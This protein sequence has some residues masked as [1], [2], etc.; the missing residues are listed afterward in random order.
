MTPLVIRMRD[1]SFISQGETVVPPQS[2]DVAAG[3]HVAQLCPT[4][5]QAHGLALLAAGLVK[6]SQGSVLIGEYDPRVQPVHCRRIA[7]YVPHD[8]MPVA[9][10]D[11]ERYVDYRAALWNIDSAHARAHAHLLLERLDGMHEAFAYPIVGALLGSPQVLVLDRPQLP[12]AV[13][14]LAAAGLS[15]VFSTHID[16]RAVDAYAAAPLAQVLV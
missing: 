16:E 12:Y 4:A 2:L 11:F 5:R 7:A 6:A 8:P 10:S 1:A 13:Q 9:P 3:S 14:I 15:A